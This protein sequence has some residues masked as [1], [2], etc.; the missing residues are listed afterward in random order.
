LR[1]G[2]FE[3]KANGTVLVPNTSC[4]VFQTTG[5]LIQQYKLPF[6]FNARSFYNDSTESYSFWTDIATK[7][8]HFYP[9]INNL[10]EFYEKDG[11]TQ[12]A[13]QQFSNS[14]K[15][16]PDNPNAWF[17]RGSIYG[18]SGQSKEAI[19]DFSQA[20]RYSP[21]F[22]QAYVNRA[23]AKAMIQDYQGALSDLDTVISK[24]KNEGAYFN[25]GILQNQMKNYSRAAS[26]FQEAIRINPSCTKCFYSLG[27]AHFYAGKYN[28][29]ATA[30]TDCLKLDPGVGNAY[31][32]RALCNIEG[33]KPDSCCADLQRAVKS[34]IKDAQPYLDKYCRQG[35]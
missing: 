11:R 30:F 17:H 6:Y 29:G 25:R 22:T 4:E 33:G 26:D 23:I 3:F 10:G 9:A 15:A 19:A 28:E 18:K 34:G 5:K 35:N 31:Y 16:N 1:N 8:P 21:G 13:F 24:E 7:Y 32:Y 2:E 14:I 12:E 27:L 20:I